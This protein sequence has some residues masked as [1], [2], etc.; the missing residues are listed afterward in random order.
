MASVTSH[1]SLRAIAFPFMHV[2]SEAVVFEEF[3][4]YG[5][6]SQAIPLLRGIRETYKLDL[7]HLTTNALVKIVCYA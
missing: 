2:P 3:F 4:H 6:H 1:M 5:L 7:S